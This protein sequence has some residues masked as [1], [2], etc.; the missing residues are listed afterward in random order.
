MR[1]DEITLRDILSQLQP[2]SSLDR[3]REKRETLLKK[4]NQSESNPE[5]PNN[6]KDMKQAFME[7]IDIDQQI[8]REIYDEKSR[9]LEIE[10]LKNEEAAAK[11]FREREIILAKHEAA[12]CRRSFNKLLSASSKCNGFRLTVKSGVSLTIREIASTGESNNL[13]KLTDRVDEVNRDVKESVEYGIAAA[14][15]A[16]RKRN[17]R[18]RKEIQETALEKKQNRKNKIKS[19]SKKRINLIV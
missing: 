3:L 6:P 5:S 10:R 1:V 18:I 19:Q 12:L 17:N 2:K 16:A 9:K 14:K 8:Q 13:S 11:K 4:I 15:V 7:L